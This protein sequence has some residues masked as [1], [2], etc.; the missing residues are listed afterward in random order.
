MFDN[1]SK[2]KIATKKSSRKKQ[3][4][5]ALFKNSAKKYRWWI[6]RIQNI[7]F[8]TTPADFL[9]KTPNYDYLIECKETIHKKIYFNRLSQLDDMLSY[10]KV[11]Q[12]HKAYFFF[13]YR[14]TQ[15]Q[16]S[17]AWLIPAH[18]IVEQLKLGKKGLEE[19]E[20]PPIYGVPYDKKTKIL[21]VYLE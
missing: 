18:Y 19:H 9:V 5:E 1:I 3:I 16:N 13:Y 8:T 2:P 4:A 15:T 12:R 17:S 10:E 14:R 20:I 21:D 11:L 7:G 6:L